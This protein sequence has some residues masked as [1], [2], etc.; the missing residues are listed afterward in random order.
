MTLITRAGILSWVELQMSTTKDTSVL[1]AL[2]F[3]IEKSTEVAEVDG[4]RTRSRE[5]VSLGAQ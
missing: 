2:R 4:W 1:R 5:K 3:A